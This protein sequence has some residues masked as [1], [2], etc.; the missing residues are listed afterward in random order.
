MRVLGGQ[1][2]A[3]GARGGRFGFVEL[4]LKGG[5]GGGKGGGGGFVAVGFVA[6]EGGVAFPRGEAVLGVVAGGGS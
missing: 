1:F 5:G 6:E 2:V 4:A 3:F